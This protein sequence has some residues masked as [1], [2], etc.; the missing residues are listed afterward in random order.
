[1]KRHVRREYMGCHLRTA[2]LEKSV[3]D[4][5]KKTMNGVSLENT[6]NGL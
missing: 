1:M 5:F 3:N 6:M 4:S 2:S